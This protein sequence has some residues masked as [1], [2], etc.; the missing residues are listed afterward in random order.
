MGVVLPGTTEAVERAMA[1]CR[2]HGAPLASGACGTGLAGQTCKVA[3]AFD[4]SKYLHRLQE[5]EKSMKG[6]K[7]REVVVVTGGTAGVGRATVRTFAGK[8]AKIAV[9]ARDRQRL[10]ETVEEAER[11]GGSAIGISADVADAAQVEAAAEDIE[12]AF[13]PMDVW[14]NNAMTSVFA[15]FMEISPEG[16]RRVTE[17]TYLGQVYGTMAALKR[18]L[19]RDRGTI[20]QA[21]SALALRSIPLQS[22]YCGAKHAVAGFTESLRTELLHDKK[23]VCVTVVHLP[24]LNTPQFDWVRSRLDKKARPVPPIFQPEVAANAIYWA[25]HHRRKEIY[26]GGST[27]LTAWVQKIVPGLLDIYLAKTGYKSQQTEEPEDRGRPDNLYN[28]VPGSHGAH[29]RFDETAHSRSLELW[30]SEHKKQ[31]G[32]GLA[33]VFAAA[34]ALALK[35]KQ[36]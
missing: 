19:P 28:P 11:L 8:G 1:V 7:K 27:M 5:A 2:R 16:F 18:M 12:R 14:I 9:L 32:A 13:G 24:A 15:P 17:V 10:R 25:A 26:V 6:K 31:I 23:N 29:G 20:V 35:G 3:V 33:G 30:M 21:G 34:A 36:K 22:A 4:F